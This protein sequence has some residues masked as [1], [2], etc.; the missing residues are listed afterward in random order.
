[1]HTSTST[2]LHQ[3][4]VYL[5]RPLTK[6]YPS[7]TVAQLQTF[8]HA[9]LASQFL[10]SEASTL[11]PFTLVLSPA[12][13]PPTPLYAACLQSGVA[14]PHWIHALGGQTMYIFVMEKNIKVRVGQVGEA[15]TVWSG[16]DEPTE[17]P[18]ISKMK[19]QTQVQAGTDYESPMAH[20]LQAMLDSVRSRNAS[21]AAV[22]KQQH[23][24][25]TLPTL[26]ST[27][28]SRSADT[29]SD[30]ISDSESDSESTT[31]SSFFSETSST[32]SMTSAAS[33]STSLSS[34][35]VSG[36][37]DLPAVIAD[38]ITKK[39]PVYVPRHRRVTPPPVS[40]S[41]SISTEHLSRSQRRLANATVDNTK[42]DI[43][44]YTY[45][46]GQTC[47]MTG[48]VMLGAVNPKPQ[49]SVPALTRGASKQKPSVSKKL[50]ANF[51]KNWRVRV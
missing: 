10:A 29:E 34:S 20:K 3:F 39:G 8:L 42:I 37:S 32:E 27:Y 16:L 49:S 24:S 15:T 30:D 44:R 22:D 31:S 12:S 46:G 18:A 40:A 13:L 47:V 25:I 48:G 41:S 36:P 7:Q 35:P 45:Q 28:L 50:G 33:S 19:T 1:M 26:L 17:V 9:N 6:V 23:R 5:T 14:W 11:S 4:V 38:T 2:A 43:C 21:A 51:S